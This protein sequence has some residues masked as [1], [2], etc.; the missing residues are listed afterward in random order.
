[1]PTTVVNLRGHRDDPAFAD[2]VYVGRALTM[3]GWRLKASTLANPYRVGRDGTPADV[4]AKYEAR[5]MSR[6]DL[7][8]LAKSLHGRR[9]GCWCAPNPCHADVI[10]MFADHICDVVGCGEEGW[11]E[12]HSNDDEKD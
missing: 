1:M 4:L 10:A 2:V 8:A 11:C 5:L 3:G 9:L 12:A 7:R 6:P